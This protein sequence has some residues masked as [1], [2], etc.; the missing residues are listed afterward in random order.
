M[1]YPYAYTGSFIICH[2]PGDDGANLILFFKRGKIFDGTRG[3]GFGVP[4]GFA[5]MS[6][7]EQL[8]DCAIREL[9]EEILLPDRSPLLP[10]ITADRLTLLD[11]GIDY[12]AGKPEANYAGVVW[13]GYRCQLTPAE[14]GTVKNHIQ[15]MDTD[16]A[17]ADAVRAASNHELDRLF[18]LPPAEAL[19]RLDSGNIPFAYDHESRVFRAVAQTLSQ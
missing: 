11:C 14:I 5:E 8:R 15:K 12:S 19:R 2:G 13:H 4:G 3:E 17:Y 6:A 10:D 9:G 7:R 18:L 1:E 16:P